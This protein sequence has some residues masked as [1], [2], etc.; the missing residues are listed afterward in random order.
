M[1]KSPCCAAPATIHGARRRLCL[2]C[3]HTWTV[4]PKRQGRKNKRARVNLAASVMLCNTSLRGLAFNKS[5]NRETIRKRFHKSLKQWLKRQIPR[6]IPDQEFLIAVVDALWF[7][8]GKHKKAYG[9]FVIML[10]PIN[11][12][13]GHIA[14]MTLLKGRESKHNWRKAF[15]KL[16]KHTTKR[17]V[18]IVADGFTGLMSIAEENEW[19]FQWCHVHIKR[20]MAELRGVRKIPGKIIRQQ[21]NKLIHQF[22]ETS[23]NGKAEVYLK[24]LRRLFALK[25]CPHSLIY[26]LSGVLRRSRFFRS[27]RAVPEY[28]L[29]VSTNSVEQ[30]NNQIRRR[31]NIMRGLK[32]TKS[33]RYWLSV[34][35][36]TMKP[37]QCRGYKETIKNHRFTHRI[38]VS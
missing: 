30:V 27:Y 26:R 13:Y 12:Q 20:R 37:I 35:H 24:E 9:C 22:L 33:L 25:E 3:H 6:P 7:K 21:A 29:P 11:S 28:N 23:D 32:S 14:V 18:A 36:K 2:R 16:P 8:L 19:H 38:S 10:R 15:N 34:M 31:M 5:I 1:R 17:I 4:R